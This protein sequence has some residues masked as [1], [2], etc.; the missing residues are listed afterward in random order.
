[1]VRGRWVFSEDENDFIEVE[2]PLVGDD[3]C[4]A[5]GECGDA[6]VLFSADDRLI[7]ARRRIGFI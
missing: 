2:Q 7:D 4:P 5:S 3:G 1:M 6:T